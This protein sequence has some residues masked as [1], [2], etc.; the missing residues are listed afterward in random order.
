MSEE[1]KSVKYPAWGLYCVENTK[2]KKKIKKNRQ[3]VQNEV[4]GSGCQEIFSIM[5]TAVFG[6]G[7]AY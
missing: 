7:G 4:T 3:D 1:K 5:V 2:K 6:C